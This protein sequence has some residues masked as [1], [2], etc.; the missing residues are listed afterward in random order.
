[1]KKNPKT[2]SDF[3]PVNPDRNLS[4]VGGSGAGKS[5][6]VMRLVQQ[7]LQR[8]KRF[9]GGFTIIDPKG[10]L[11]RYFSDSSESGDVQSTRMR[12]PEESTD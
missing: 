7:E 10:E 11:A 3:E 9:H 6:M 1:M 8:S 4:I 5:Y 2:V 12:D